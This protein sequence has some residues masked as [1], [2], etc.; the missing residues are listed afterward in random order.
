MST[1][2]LLED[3]TDF[4]ELDLEVRIS[5]IDGEGPA[6]AAGSGTSPNTHGDPCQLCCW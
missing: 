5:E 2:L 4:T 1:N 3:T 6:F